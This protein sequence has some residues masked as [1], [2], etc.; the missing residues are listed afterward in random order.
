M[1]TARRSVR[2][3]TLRRSGS[4]GQRS[5]A[6]R[7]TMR[8]L[9]RRT[10]GNPERVVRNSRAR[11]WASVRLMPRTAAASSTV[12][13]GRSLG[14]GRIETDRDTRASTGWCGCVV[15][16]DAAFLGTYISVSAIG[17]AAEISQKDRN[18]LVAPH[19]CQSHRNRPERNRIFR[20]STPAGPWLPLPADRSGGVKTDTDS[21]RGRTTLTSTRG[22]A[23]AYQPQF[24]D[25]EF[26]MLEMTSF[27]R[28]DRLDAE[29][30]DHAMRAGT[31]MKP[32]MGRSI[33]LS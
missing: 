29:R 5:R 17:C 16:S 27:P 3:F 20:P 21:E 12:K 11:L 13:N 19:R 31:I 7:G 18:T 32:E 24:S 1:T 4:Q 30:D 2:G 23:H 26:G 15:P 28:S 9:P 6:A 8:R 22:S 25:P 10:Q 14:G 33:G